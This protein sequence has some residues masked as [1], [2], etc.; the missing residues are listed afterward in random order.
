MMG[1]LVWLGELRVSGVV[2]NI[3]KDFFS[4][5]LLGND[6]LVFQG[7]SV[8]RSF[9]VVKTPVSFDMLGAVVD[10]LGVKILK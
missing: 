8:W 5:V 3:E 1:E 9:S 7:D 2:L 6:F 10:G 4:V